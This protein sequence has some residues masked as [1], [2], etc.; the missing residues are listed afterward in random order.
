MSQALAH[1]PF[2]SYAGIYVCAIAAALFVIP[3]DWWELPRHQD[4]A[5]LAAFL[6]LVVYLVF[7]DA[8]EPAALRTFAGLVCGLSIAVIHSSGPLGALLSAAICSALGRF[9]IDWAA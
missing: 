3:L 4:L 1:R 6:A 8:R 7:V 9:G 5:T 2:K